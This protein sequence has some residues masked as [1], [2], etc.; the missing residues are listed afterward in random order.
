MT[1]IYMYVC[2]YVFMYICVYMCC[3]KDIN[4]NDFFIFVKQVIKEWK[5][6]VIWLISFIAF[7]ILLVYTHTDRH[8]KA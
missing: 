5:K 7:V 6:I 8:T 2:V 4:I 1:V 3:K